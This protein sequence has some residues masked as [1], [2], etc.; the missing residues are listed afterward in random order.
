MKTSNEK[1]YRVRAA[2]LSALADLKAP[3]AYDTLT[4]AVKT[5]SPDNIIRDAG[6]AG[7]GRL[8]DDR[9]VPL[10]LEWSG[11]GKDQQ[12]RQ[13]AMMAVGRLDKKNKE[14]TKALVAYLHEPY[15]D[16]SFWGLFAIGERGDADAIA[17]LEEMLKSD[18]VTAN[19]KTMIESQI[20][21][22]KAHAA[23]KN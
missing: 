15:F 13:V 23:S 1:A 12:T 20:E 18:D 14:I 22:L 6:L 7:L 5:D 21:V 16:V 4:T 2:A 8:G 10:L 3:N 9:A 17:P 19:Q 11:P